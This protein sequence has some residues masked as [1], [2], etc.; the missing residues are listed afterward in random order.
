VKKT[1]GEGR[2]TGSGISAVDASP[3]VALYA[4]R[5]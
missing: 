5:P 3:V 4:G 1:D 2:C